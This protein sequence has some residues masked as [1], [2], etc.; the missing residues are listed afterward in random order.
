MLKRKQ[1]FVLFIGRFQ[2][3]HNG[4]KRLLHYL[5]KKYS[6]IC[7]AIGSSN[8]K[9]TSQN[10]F[11]AYER[12]SMIKKAIGLSPAWL[13]KKISIALLPDFEKNKDW[14]DY[15]KSRFPPIHY[16]IA[17]ANPLVRRLLLAAGYELDASP[18]FNRARLEGKRIRQLIKS[19]LPTNSCLPACVRN[20]MEKK[21]RK[22]IFNS[23][24]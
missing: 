21:G 24:A 1:K 2:P 3:F 22:I 9:R 16:S 20:W 13:G 23:Q 4:H 15:I 5:G 19:G 12:R 18:L 17:S 11:S 14:V 10:P 7:I 6:H 8:K